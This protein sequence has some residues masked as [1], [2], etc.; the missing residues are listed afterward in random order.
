MREDGTQKEKKN[1]HV[2]KKKRMIMSDQKIIIAMILSKDDRVNMIIIKGRGK[3]ENEF[4]FFGILDSIFSHR[5][6]HTPLSHP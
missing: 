2:M 6:N 1:V 5:L 4:G 3:R